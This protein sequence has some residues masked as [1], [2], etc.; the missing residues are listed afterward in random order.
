MREK[1]AP[2]SRRLAEAE[3]RDGSIELGLSPRG[4]GIKVSCGV[5]LEWR[6]CVGTNSGCVG[7]GSWLDG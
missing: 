3:I 7:P 6:S 2:S 1:G 5:A 4:Y